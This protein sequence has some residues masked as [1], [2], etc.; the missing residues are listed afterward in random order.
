MRPLVLTLSLCCTLAS[1]ALAQLPRLAIND[2]R[3][4][5]GVLK[6]GVLELQLEI[7][8]GMWHPD[9]ESAIGI[10]AIA[11]GETGRT[12]TLP[13]PLIRV[14]RG[15]V[16]RTTLHNT[17]DES[18][19][20][21]GL[22]SHG[23]ADTVRLQAGESRNFEM[24]AAEVGTYVY[25]TMRRFRVASPEVPAQGSDMTAVGAFIVDDPAVKR[26]DRIF[27]INMMV[28]TLKIPRTP[29]R[30]SIIATLNGKAW[31]HTERPVHQVGDTVVW[32]VINASLI[33]HPMHL[34]GF[35][36][37]VLTRGRDAEDTIYTPQQVRKAV[38]ERLIPFSSM[39]MSWV[40]ERAG[41]WL[42]HCHLP[43]H[44]ALRSPIGGAMKAS[45]PQPHAHDVMNG[46]SNLMMGVKVTGPEPRDVAS[47][48]QL[49]L[50]VDGGD[51]IA[52]D[53]RPRFRYSLD[54]AANSK[55][56]GPTIVLQQNQP[57]AITVVNRTRETTA[58]HW[59][60]IELESFNDG[61]AGFGGHG[62][63]I[64]PL[65]EPGD[66]F[67]ARMTPPRAGT[68]I[69]HTHVDELRQMPTLHGALVVAPPGGTLD[70]S[71]ERVIVL[72]SP[73][74]NTDIV[75]NGEHQPDMVLEAG[76][77]Y[78]LRLIHIMIAR[79]AMYV[80]LLDPEGKPEKWT[81]AAKDGADL[82]AHQ[83][84]VVQARQN[85]SNGETYD[86]IFTPRTAGTWKLE[87]R[88]GSG[89]PFGQ[90]TLTAR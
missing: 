89:R 7:T 8:K 9:G 47:R 52:G 49:H 32:R 12:P 70:E 53:L 88:A 71:S 13:P 35:Y 69:Y 66:S 76:K 2:N 43:V 46:M 78:R 75:F 3:T 59:H 58:V 90:M 26:A 19:M 22:G 39:T 38:T 68:F 30:T 80:I 16:V 36:F 4:P 42:F 55:G 24:T 11:I 79:P 31:P 29:G 57:T 33:P 67:T 81:L 44:T 87:A 14:P 62:N 27:V 56:A 51:S 25:G 84:A 77:T 83:R 86:V 65:I 5:S 64:T 63:R 54:G 74:D 72:G 28:D 37:D 6:N 10:E 85:M 45:Q 1:S 73:T 17:L 34:H 41:N 48:R 50:F 82:P 18:M 23:L 20:V 60:G 21:W 61:V 15:T 40:P